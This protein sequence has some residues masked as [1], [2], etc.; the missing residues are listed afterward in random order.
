MKRR[1]FNTADYIIYLALGL[2]ALSIV[3]PF[4]HMFSLSFSPSLCGDKRGPA[5]V[6]EGFYH[7]QLF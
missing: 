6:A 1:R 7:R 4:L 3:V 2:L 5:P